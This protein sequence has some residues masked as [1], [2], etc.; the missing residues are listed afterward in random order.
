MFKN[1]LEGICNKRKALPVVVNRIYSHM[2]LV[3][4][5]CLEQYSEYSNCIQILSV[6]RNHGRQ[7]IGWFRRRWFNKKHHQHECKWYLTELLHESYVC[8][9]NF[10]PRRSWMIGLV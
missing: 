6:P 1:T 9:N 3:G 8:K 10:H 7:L 5:S 4:I 2:L